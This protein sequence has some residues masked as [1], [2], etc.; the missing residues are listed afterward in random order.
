MHD[1]MEKEMNKFRISLEKSFRERTALK[2]QNCNNKCN[3]WN[4]AYRIHY[5]YIWIESGV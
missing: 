4:Y 5:K 1:C 2:L 3:E